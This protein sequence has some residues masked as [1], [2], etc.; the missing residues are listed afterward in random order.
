MSTIIRKALPE[1]STAVYVIE[2]EISRHPW[3]EDQ[4]REE[5]EFVQAF[6][7]VCEADGR[8]VG[9]A[10]MQNAAEFAHIN[11]LGV[12]ASH[13]R[14]GIGRMLMEDIIR[15]SLERGCE[16]ISLEV[17]ESNDPAQALYR[18]FGFRQEGLRKGFYRDPQE[19]G[20]VLVKKLKE[21]TD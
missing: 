9:F 2:N 13:R 5:I 7:C 10:T 4:I 17:R 18:S 19:D 11:E 20:L 16:F 6:T 8:I 12:L 1:D 3:T 21:E 15:E 14:R